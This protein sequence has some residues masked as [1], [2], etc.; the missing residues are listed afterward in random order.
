MESRDT[1]INW[2]T[3]HSK[4]VNFPQIYTVLY[5]VSHSY[6]NPS[7]ISFFANIDKIIL[8]FMWK[9]EQLKRFWKKIEW[10]K[11]C[12]VSAVRTTVYGIGRGTDSEINEIK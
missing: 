5:S 7:K 9:G 2:K 10:E 1:L 12:P 4:D 8:K 11:V 3:H 6:Q